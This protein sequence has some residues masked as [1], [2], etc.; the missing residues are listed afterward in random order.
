M[1]TKAVKLVAMDLDGTLTQH[2]TMLEGAN[3]EALDR[4][5][6]TYRLLMVGAG[7]CTRI[8]R[9]MEQY[10][11]DI[12]GNYGL[13]YSRYDANEKTLK[14][15]FDRK[16]P[17]DWEVVRERIDALRNSLGYVRYT[18]DSVEFHESGCV[19]FPLLGTKAS[20][21]KKLS[22][23]PDRS[24]RR[25]MYAEVVAAFPEYCVFIGGSSSFD[26]APSPYDKF[27]ALDSFCRQE[28]LRHEN[29]VYIGDDYG[30][31][32]NDEAV[33]R[34][35]FSFLTIDDY[36]DFPRVAGSLLSAQGD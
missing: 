24:L 34:S 25:K 17:C 3:R 13:Q 27:H 4:L 14:T 15:V 16:L 12:I 19:T 8:F 35:D 7:Q 33:Y 1:N 28:G 11:V 10:P 20:L 21:D 31:G 23:D 6:R 26:L 32:G 18:G 9:Q 2:K 5:G 22:F 30:L 36:R 29:V